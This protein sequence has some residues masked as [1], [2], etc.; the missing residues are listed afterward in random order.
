MTTLIISLKKWEPIKT[1]LV[2]TYGKKI[3]ISFITKKK[4]G[5][6]IRYYNDYNKGWDEYTIE[7]R[8]VRLDFY[9]EQ[10]KTM[11]LLKYSEML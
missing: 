5:C 3:L 7:T 8:D 9:N 2:E 11:F 1:Q 10:K 4:L 6:T